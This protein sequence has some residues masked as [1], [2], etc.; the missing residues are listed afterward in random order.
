MRHVRL[1][2][3]DDEHGNLGLIIK[4]TPKE[5]GIF[6]SSDGLLIAHDLL[7]HQQGVKKIG[8]PEDELIALGAVWHMRARWGTMLTKHQNIWSME[9]NLGLNIESVWRDLDGCGWWPGGKRYRT[10]AHD[11]D[12]SFD[13]ALEFTRKHMIEDAE[14]SENVADM[15]A[16]L[17]DA[18]H[19]LRIGYRKSERRFGTGFDGADQ[20]CAV[21][22]AVNRIVPLVE[23]EG[24]EFILAYGNGEARCYEARVEAW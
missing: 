15:D 22:D 17:T 13:A 4:G 9:E 2:T 14:A 10:H 7:E 5:E 18:K 12:E 8:C 19:L 23:I 3:W 20:M 24:Q 11:H 1:E 6:S 16:F 21:R